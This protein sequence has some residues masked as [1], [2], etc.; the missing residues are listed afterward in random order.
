MPTRAP[1]FLVFLL[2]TLPVAFGQTPTITSISPISV[3][4]TGPAFT[5]TVNGF[6]FDPTCQ[7]QWAVPN[8]ASG[9]MPSS[10][11]LTTTFV[12]AT[13]LT[14]AVPASLIA[15]PGSLSIL[16]ESFSTSNRQ[17]NTLA[18][19]MTVPQPVIT[20]LSEYSVNAGSPGTSVTI[21]GTGLI[22][23]S[24]AYW[25]NVALVT[26][27]Q[28][29]AAPSLLA[30]VPASLLATGGSA[31]ITV[32]NPGNLTPSGGI[33]FTIAPV[34][35]PITATSITPNVVAFGGPDLTITINGS[36]FAPGA[37]AYAQGTTPGSIWTN[38]V[39]TFVSSTQLTAALP[40]WITAGPIQFQIYVNSGGVIEG[41]PIFTV[42][43][44]TPVITGAGLSRATPQYELLIYGSN[45]VDGAVVNWA[46]TPLP[47]FYMGQFMLSAL[48][49][50]NLRT[51]GA[52]GV[53]VTNPSGETSNAVTIDIPPVI[54][55]FHPHRQWRRLFR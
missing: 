12:S 21:Q 5:I 20:S 35:V 8:N 11:L 10:N 3:V 28:T 6:G 55:V 24:T 44:L 4:A 36:G 31:T 13:Q 17:S 49:P 46:G 9:A 50:D 1:R 38:F 37:V 27:Y 23:T 54:S 18:L 25:N 33:D 30:T 45:F 53:T 29:M 14:A 52:W 26:G 41:G 51:V 42:T 47:T 7:V 43:G 32:V 16:V 40:A 34:S 2:C 19:T 48:V 15:N 22:S 39:T